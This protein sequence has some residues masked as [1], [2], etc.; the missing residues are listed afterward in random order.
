MSLL[1]LALLIQ[2]EMMP[3]P[4]KHHEHLKAFVGTWEATVTMKDPGGME[5]EGKGTETNKLI[6]GG[7]WLVTD[8]EG[9]FGGMDFIGHGT[10]GYDPSEKKYVGT[11]IDS[12]TDYIGHS[13]GE[14]SEDGKTFTMMVKVKD[15]ETGEWTEMKEVSK[16]VDKDTKT[17]TFHNKVEEGW[18]EF[19]KIEYTRKK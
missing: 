9:D 7:L 11:W 18:A 5:M 19:M 16:I 3:K 17:L 1:A 14:V 10:M 4:G 2:D 15:H 6:A 8:Y 12:F 13:S